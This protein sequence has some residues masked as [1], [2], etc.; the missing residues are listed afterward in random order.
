LTHQAIASA[1]PA[2]PPAIRWVLSGIFSFGVGG[3]E[4]EG[5]IGLLWLDEPS[6]ADLIDI[7]VF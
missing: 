6:N 7:L 1:K 5:D 3:V 4:G 2:I